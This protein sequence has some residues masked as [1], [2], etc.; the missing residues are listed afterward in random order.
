MTNPLEEAIPNED[1]QAIIDRN[2]EIVRLWAKS[3]SHQKIAEHFGVSRVRITQILGNIRSNW[4]K[5]FM[6]DYNFFVNRELARI[7]ALEAEAWEAWERSK[8]ALK[9]VK[10]K[11]GMERGVDTDLTELEYLADDQSRLVTAEGNHYFLK[12]VESCINMRIRVLG[13]TAKDKRDADK[14]TRQNQM[15]D[16]MVESLK[17]G[18]TTVDVVKSFFP[19]AVYE[20]VFIKSGL[21][22][23][24]NKP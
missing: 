6:E 17:N 7:D 16:E 19:P 1:E 11:T 2:K 5:E 15:I 22:K 8:R 18:N 14:Q 12:Q 3:W 24:G 10:Y 9:S 23:N 20:E 4:K 13:L 21:D